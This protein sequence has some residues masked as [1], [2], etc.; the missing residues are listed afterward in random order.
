MSLE[1][2]GEKR[3]K[4]NHGNGG[5]KSVI[6]L[7][8]AASSCKRSNDCNVCGSECSDCSDEIEADLDPAS[9]NGRLSMSWQSLDKGRQAG[10]KK[11]RD[12]GW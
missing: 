2:E 4:R 9:W 12:D 8:D 11:L 10:R 5:S 3:M 7:E 1:K 6:V